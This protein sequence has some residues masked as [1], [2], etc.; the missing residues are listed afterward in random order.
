MMLV[1]ELVVYQYPIT[2]LDVLDYPR[3]HTPR[4]HRLCASGS[5]MP[6]AFRLAIVHG[7][8]QHCLD[9]DD[10]DDDDCDIDDDDSNRMRLPSIWVTAISSPV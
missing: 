9:D 10:D 6:M 3:S 4:R 1:A 5:I 8:M 7:H 2:C